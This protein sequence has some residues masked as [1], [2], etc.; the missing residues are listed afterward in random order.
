[1]SQRTRVAGDCVKSGTF[2]PI[3]L[4]LKWLLLAEIDASRKAAFLTNCFRWRSR[5]L[6]VQPPL[7]LRQAFVG[8]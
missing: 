8:A 2:A 7:Q 6:A 5:S 3:P 4:R 1:M